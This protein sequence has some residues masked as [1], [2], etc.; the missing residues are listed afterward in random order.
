[1][2]KIEFRGKDK[3]EQSSWYD[4]V[5]GYFTKHGDNYFINGTLV[6]PKT[7]GQFTGLLDKNRK[8]IFEGDIIR[9]ET[10]NYDMEGNRNHIV[11]DFIMEYRIETNPS[12]NDGVMSSEFLLKDIIK[13]DYEYSAIFRSCKIKVIGNI[14]DNPELLKESK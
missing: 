11:K 5:H 8:K 1:M 2:R 7:V 4:W 14:H 13:S 3:Y 12:K 10:Y 9:F 6:E